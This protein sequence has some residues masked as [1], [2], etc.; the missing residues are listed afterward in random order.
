MQSGVVNNNPR[1]LV[2]IESTGR[3]SSSVRALIGLIRIALI[4]VILSRSSLSQEHRG[5]LQVP[6]DVVVAV[7]SSASMR[8]TDPERIRVAAVQAFLKALGADDRVSLLEFGDAT[9]VLSGFVSVNPAALP[10]LVAQVEK[11]SAGGE[12]T[13]ILDGLIKS[14]ELLTAQ[15]R[16]H[17]RKLVILLSDG[18]L[19][20]P[21]AKYTAEKA[22]QVLM[23]EVV[24][25]LKGAGI[26]VHTV[27]FSSLVDKDLLSQ[28]SVGTDGVTWFSEG[29]NGLKEAF[30]NLL[31]V[32]KRPV[33]DGSEARIFTI[34]DDVEEVTFYVRREDGTSVT[35][36]D[37]K[38]Q[39]LDSDTKGDQIT[40]F[41]NKT[42]DVATI[43]APVA[44]DWAVLG[45][46]A[47]KGFA[48][49]LPNLRLALTWPQVLFVDQEFRLEAR[50]LDGEKPII[51]PD[52]SAI[53]DFR[54][55][56]VSTDK[57]TEPVIEDSLS[58]E[59][60]NGDLQALDGVFAKTIKLSHEGEYKLRVLVRTPT[61]TR[62]QMVPFRVRQEL[63]R[64]AVQEHKGAF[65]QLIHGDEHGDEEHG[66]GDH[67][68]DQ[69]TAHGQ[70]SDEHS[71]EGGVATTEHGEHGESQSEHVEEEV[72]SVARVDLLP[73]VMLAKKFSVDVTAKSHKTDKI[74]TLPC[75]H[76]KNEQ[77]CFADLSVLN[78]PM[79]Y[80]I[81]GS[82]KLQ[83]KRGPE[84][85]YK[86]QPVEFDAPKVDR[87]V[88]EVVVK[89]TLTIPLIL[90]SVLPLGVAVYFLVRFW[91]REH[92]DVEEKIVYR[93]PSELTS[94]VEQLTHITEVHEIEKSD[95]RFYGASV[96]DGGY[97]A[98][99]GAT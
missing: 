70:H 96:E 30:A 95:A 34:D 8:L 56:I 73:E 91:P 18:K 25:Q 17:A 85:K 58:D 12:R 41:K 54:V 75:R 97:S 89:P 29:A 93:I 23:Q 88:I 92:T 28:I 36:R 63:V 7:D 6:V 32:A 52:L 87:K 31:L 21:P 24:P 49:A 83:P 4:L 10:G 67:G 65:D 37:P 68:H 82:L 78:G 43:V 46:P 3:R 26:A 64:V 9:K 27:A 2:L 84:E 66:K 35:I 5:T 61:F 80:E 71:A 1:D 16:P 44:G 55:Q 51:L 45:L 86:S 40:W 33:A 47:T 98:G 60:Q 13:D 20:P 50:L 69:A 14:K 76:G 15:G 81:R 72:I 57:I 19:D 59:G 38:A 11:L 77:T 90:V 42:V 74:Q 22:T 79:T 39:I 53:A 94:L 62:D 99:E 48:A